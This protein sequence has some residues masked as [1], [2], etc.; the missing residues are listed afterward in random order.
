[1]ARPGYLAGQEREIAVLFADLRQFTALAERRLL[2]DVVFLL[3]RYCEV[4]G[5]SIDAAGIGE[6]VGRPQLRFVPITSVEQQEMPALPC[7]R[8]RQIKSRTAVV[9]QLRGL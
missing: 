7:M 8:E 1:M 5:T 3:N 4:I 6:A 9:N 2:Y